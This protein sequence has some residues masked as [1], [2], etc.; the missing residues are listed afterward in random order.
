MSEV[1]FVYVLKSTVANRT[2]VGIAL[3]PTTRLAEH[4]GERSGGAKATRGW[5]P[6]VIG[7]VYGPI[8]NKGEALQLEHRIKQE[9]G[10]ARLLVEWEPICD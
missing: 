3:D 6:W 7:R 9:E 1:W 10:A 8:R 4:N 5:R 2:Y